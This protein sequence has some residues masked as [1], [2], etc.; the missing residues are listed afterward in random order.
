MGAK[1]PAPV[2]FPEATN[3]VGDRQ[4]DHDHVDQQTLNQALQAVRPSCMKRGERKNNEIHEFLNRSAKEQAAN[5]RVLLQKE[6]PPA[7]RIVGSRRRESN[8]EVQANAKNI[9]SRVPVANNLS[10]QQTCGNR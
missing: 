1:E 8:Q 10:T 2:L 4:S 9:N 6:Q 5:Q 3:A 7:R